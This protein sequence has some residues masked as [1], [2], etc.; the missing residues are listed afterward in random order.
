MYEHIY[1][2]VRKWKSERASKKSER[3]S[4][5]AKERAR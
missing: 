3:A 1:E 2:R 5:K 4:A